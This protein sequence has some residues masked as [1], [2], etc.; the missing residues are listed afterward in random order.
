MSIE[1]TLASLQPYVIGIRY[2]DGEPLIDAVFKEGWNVPDDPKI[3]KIKGSEEMNYFMLMSEVKDEV[4][5]DALLGFV[6]RTIKLNIEREKK[7]DLL[8]SKFNELKDIFKKNPLEKLKNLK[9]VFGEED[10]VPPLNDFDMDDAFDEEEIQPQPLLSEK[11]VPE[12]FNEEPIT[13]QGPIDQMAYVDEEGNEIPLSQED[14][15]IIAEEAR[16]EKNRQFLE[17]K[18]KKNETRKIAKNVELPPKRK[19]VLETTIDSPFCECG[20]DEACGRCIDSKGF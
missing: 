12:Q 8:K 9:F 4:G 16:A 2:L 11:L 10:M 13:S 1:K 14:L 6:D 18:S 15:E 7:H 19:A 20:P 17:S 5:V 3:K